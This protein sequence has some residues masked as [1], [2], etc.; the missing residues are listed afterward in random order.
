MKKLLGLCAVA[1]VAICAL[2]TSASAQTVRSIT[3]GWTAPHDSVSSGATN[4]AVKS[5]EIRYAQDSA[6]AAGWTG[7][8]VIPTSLVIVPKAPGQAETFTFSVVQTDGA[9]IWAVLRA[10]DVAGN[11]SKNSNIP[12]I[13]I[14][15]I[16][17][18]SSVIDLKV[19][20]IF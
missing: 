12:P 18:P 1:M 17:A 19:I 16:T 4:V 10:K 5:Y 20:S 7:A 6:T 9:T 11:Q 14:P 8:T 2:T 3:L 15:D 13:L